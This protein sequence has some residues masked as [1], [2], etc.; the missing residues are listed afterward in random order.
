[1]PTRERETD[2]AQSGYTSVLGAIEDGK[3]KPRQPRKQT[4]AKTK[5]NQELQ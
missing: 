5:D 4:A 2:K 1:M 3:K